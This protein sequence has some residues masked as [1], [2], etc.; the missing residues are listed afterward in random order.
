MR[1]CVCARGLP[2]SLS[3]CLVVAAA[4]LPSSPLLPSARSTSP[5]MVHSGPSQSSSISMS[6]MEAMPSHVAALGAANAPAV[7]HVSD[8]AD[9]AYEGGD[10]DDDDFEN[11]AS[12]HD[13]DHDNAHT[14]DEDRAHARRRRRDKKK[15]HKKDKGKKAAAAAAATEAGVSSVPTN[16]G[17]TVT[18]ATSASMSP[19]SVKSDSRQGASHGPVPVSQHKPPQPP[20]CLHPTCF[21]HRSHS[22]MQRRKPRPA[23]PFR[24]LRAS[25]PR[26]FHP[27]PTVRGSL[28]RMAEL[29]DAVDSKSTAP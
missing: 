26:P 8:G 14:E 1:V 17:L 28:A 4:V 5:V 15:S 22:P 12:D 3:A 9:D 6:V 24:S 19:H 2:V 10:Y 7:A 18:S 11:D 23:R 25:S 21:A 29:A 27:A 13:H 16:S 20:M